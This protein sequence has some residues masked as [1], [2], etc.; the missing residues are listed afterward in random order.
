MGVLQVL[1]IVAGVLS[2]VAILAVV[3]I[4]AYPEL[5]TRRRRSGARNVAS[6]AR[7]SPAV[8]VISKVSR[9]GRTTV[10]PRRKTT[11]LTDGTDRKTERAPGASQPRLF[12]IRSIVSVVNLT[13]WR[14]PG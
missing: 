11:D 14:E 5:T 9:L 4:A 7:K 3:L 13:C 12:L 2:L 1:L 6:N 8:P 10:E